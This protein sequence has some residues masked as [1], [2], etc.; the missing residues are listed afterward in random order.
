MIPEVNCSRRAGDRVCPRPAEVRVNY[1]DNATGA[2]R[3]RENLCPLHAMAAV[4]A[5]FVD[6]DRDA[7]PMTVIVSPL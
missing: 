5:A 2:T 3:T 7:A 4:T 1:V 6:V